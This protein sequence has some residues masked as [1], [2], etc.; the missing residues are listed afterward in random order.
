MAEVVEGLPLPASPTWNHYDGT[1][2]ISQKSRATRSWMAILGRRFLLVAI[3]CRPVLAT[4]RLRSSGLSLFPVSTG[5]CT[6]AVLAG[7]WF[8]RSHPVVFAWC[9]GCPVSWWMTRNRRG[10]RNV[11]RTQ[12]WRSPREQARETMD[13]VWAVRFILRIAL[14]ASCARSSFPSRSFP[15][16][17]GVPFRRFAGDEHGFVHTDL[18]FVS[19]TSQFPALCARAV[20][21]A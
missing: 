1:V 8:S 16:F 3:V 2:F 6:F 12:A 18:G 15:A 19:L 13:E 5:P 20:A 11:E 10:S 4:W 9:F 7:L 17:R 14:N 21:A